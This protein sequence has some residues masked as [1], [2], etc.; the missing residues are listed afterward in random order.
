VPSITGYNPQKRSKRG[1]NAP[2]VPDPDGMWSGMT[3]GLARDGDGFCDV[4]HMPGD[5]RKIGPLP[6]QNPHYDD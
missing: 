5:T 4:D 6:D 2:T 3:L 1:E